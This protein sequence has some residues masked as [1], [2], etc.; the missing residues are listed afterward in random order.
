[1]PGISPNSN[2]GDPGGGGW[3]CSSDCESERVKDCTV[4]CFIEPIMYYGFY[5]ANGGLNSG[6]QIRW[7]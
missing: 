1:M 4:M 5:F 7:P 2:T 6:M 3:D